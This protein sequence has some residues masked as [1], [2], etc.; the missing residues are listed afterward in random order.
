MSLSWIDEYI[1]IVTDDHDFYYENPIYLSTYLL[2]KRN[3]LFKIIKS[4]QIIQI[5][6]SIGYSNEFISNN[7]INNLTDNFIGIDKGWIIDFICCIIKLNDE[8][9]F[10]GHFRP[11]I[12]PIYESEAN[13]F[14][15]DFLLDLENPK[16]KLKSYINEFAKRGITLGVEKNQLFYS[17]IILRD[18]I[19]MSMVYVLNMNAILINK[20]KIK[21]IILDEKLINKF[22]DK[23][24]GFYNF[25]NL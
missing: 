1:E 25:I 11:D 22:Q 21:K 2:I 3:S 6:K 13:F 19:L 5:L 15:H 24:F 4:V 16:K 23:T 10:I 9:S 18:K 12:F 20:D 17:N 14:K 8:Y 7:N